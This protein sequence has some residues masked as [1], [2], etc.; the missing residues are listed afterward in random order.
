MTLRLTKRPGFLPLA[1]GVVG[2]AAV[3]IL[4]PFSGGTDTLAGFVSAYALVLLSAGSLLY[5][6]L[7]LTLGCAAVLLAML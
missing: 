5:G 2:F 1:L 7:T 4:L 6:L 3:V